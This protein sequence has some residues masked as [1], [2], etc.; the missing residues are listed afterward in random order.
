MN[1][2]EVAAVK[3]VARALALVAALCW[4]SACS[5]VHGSHQKVQISTNVPAKIYLGDRLIAETDGVPTTVKLRR[6]KTHFIT[7][8]APGY[9]EAYT[10]LQRELTFLGTLDLLGALLITLPVV[11]FASGHAYSV[12]PGE[13]QLDLERSGPNADASADATR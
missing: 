8:K 6:G 7:A 11:T 1:D 9:D 5:F 12:S 3:F 2:G 4:L 13:L 10:S